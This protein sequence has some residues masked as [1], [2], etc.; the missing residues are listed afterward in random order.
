M[1][2]DS[3][4][5][6]N[7]IFISIITGVVISI[8]Y[9]IF[10]SIRKVL[11]CSIISIVIQDLIF[12]IIASLLT[13][14]IL[15][16]RVKGEIRWF[17]LFFELIGFIISKITVSKKIETVLIK[18][19]KCLIKYLFKPLIS[20]YSFIILKLNIIF[21]NLISKTLKKTWSVYAF[22]V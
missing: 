9:S 22:V 19:I 3:V 2:I 21:D 13:F 16:V 15:L 11:R 20:I 5:D 6:F 12:S 17:V 8:I 7:S 4:L 18:T 1:R 10:K 14:L